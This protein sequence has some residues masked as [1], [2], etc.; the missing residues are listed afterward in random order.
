MNIAKFL[1]TAFYRTPLVAALP[2]PRYPYVTSERGNNN[3]C[4][5]VKFTVQGK[6]NNLFI[7]KYDNSSNNLK[8]NNSKK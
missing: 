5:Q 7:Q 4:F 3:I 1:R 8:K 2:P 6:E